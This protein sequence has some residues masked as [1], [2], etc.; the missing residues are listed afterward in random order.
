MCEIKLHVK[1]PIFVARQWI[2]HRTA[3]VNEYSARYSVLDKEFYLPDADAVAAQSSSNRQGRG[4]SFGGDEAERVRSLM[5]GDA[6]R[7]YANYLEM[8]N[9]D[10]TGA[11][12]EEGRAGVARELARANLPVSFY[13]QWYW[14]TDLH[15]FMRFVQLRSD[16]HAQWEIRQ[17]A[18]VLL[19]LLAAWVPHTF[20]AFQDY[21]MGSFALSREASRVVAEWIAGRRPLREDTALSPREWDELVGR[22]GPS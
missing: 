4:Q 16:A 22:F 13:T 8:L 6:E 14:K 20:E 1:L 10:G 15:N 17:Y 21:Q 9:D 11:V 5:A 12:L 3:S 7:A 2:R 18:E 19:R